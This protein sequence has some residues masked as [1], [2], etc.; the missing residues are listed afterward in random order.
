M[1]SAWITNC[2]IVILLR[3]ELGN[4]Q[5]HWCENST[6]HDRR[7][8]G[9]PC[10]GTLFTD[11]SSFT[12][13]A[14]GFHISIAQSQR[15]P[16]RVR[17]SSLQLAVPQPLNLSGWI[18]PSCHVEYPHEDMEHTE[19]GGCKEALIPSI[20]AAASSSCDEDDHRD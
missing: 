20:L 4:C 14:Y 13:L 6:Q 17:S 2:D 5:G 12:S 9:A 1:A 10:T 11:F 18:C 7:W 19:C 16:S 15:I 3:L 8:L